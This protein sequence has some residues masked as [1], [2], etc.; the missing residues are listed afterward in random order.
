MAGH[1]ALNRT[2]EAAHDNVWRGSIC[3]GYFDFGDHQALVP[4]IRS[5]DGR[6]ERIYVVL[7]KLTGISGMGSQPPEGSLN[8]KTPDPEII[9]WRCPFNPEYERPVVLQLSGGALVYR[10]R[11]QNCPKN[12]SH[13]L[14]FHIEPHYREL[15]SRPIIGRFGGSTGTRPIDRF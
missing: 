4:A 13:A 2:P 11:H 7:N 10:C 9:K 15:T 3:A 14:R 12:D 6:A 8:N 1:L 5:A